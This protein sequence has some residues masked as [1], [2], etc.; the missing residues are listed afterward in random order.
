MTNEQRLAFDERFYGRMEPREHE[1]PSIGVC[2]YCGELVH[3][4]EKH[5]DFDGILFHSECLENFGAA[6]V[7]ELMGYKE[8]E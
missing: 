2:R 1:W 3:E 6:A 4:G 7:A 5:Y 8:A